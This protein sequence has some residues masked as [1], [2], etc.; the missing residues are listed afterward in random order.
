M[1]KKN[2]KI[3]QFIPYILGGGILYWIITT[4][5]KQTIENINKFTYSLGKMKFD[6][7]TSKRNYYTRLYFNT[8]LLIQNPTNTSIT[9]KSVNF[10]FY[11]EG[12]KIG[13]F[14]DNKSFVV[15][16]NTTTTK[17]LLVQFSTLNLTTGIINAIKNKKLKI[18][19]KGDI[20]TNA[21]AIKY[22]DSIDIL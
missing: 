17:M 7:D 5:S 14:N 11:S 15:A 8:E 4:Y 12:V 3:L 20:K 2:Q 1:S 9:I 13:E 22:T 21:I 16:P 10:E 19:Y 18:D 6:N